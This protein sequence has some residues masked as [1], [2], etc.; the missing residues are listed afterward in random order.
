MGDRCPECEGLM[1]KCI[2]C[3]VFTCENCGGHGEAPAD[4]R[5]ESCPDD[6]RAAGWS[7]A[8]HNDYRLNGQP[9]TFWLFTSGDRNVKGEGRTDA[10]A[11]GQ[12]REQAGLVESAARERG[13]EGR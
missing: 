13:H 11:L 2:S 5:V 1:E 10:E 4:P 3:C 12:C 8:V 6:L 7:V 9:H